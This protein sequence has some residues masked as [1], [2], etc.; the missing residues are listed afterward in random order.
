[1]QQAKSRTRGWSKKFLY[2]NNQ[3]CSSYFLLYKI[4]PCIKYM[5][6]ES[7]QNFMEAVFIYSLII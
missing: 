5:L 4:K 3:F 6:C 7:F 2:F 1:M